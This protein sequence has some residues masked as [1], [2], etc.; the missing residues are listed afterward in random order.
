[1]AVANITAMNGKNS[2]IYISTTA[3]GQIY[4][5]NAWSI[6]LS[7]DNTEYAV[8]DDDWKSN[9]SGLMGYSLTIGAVSD[10]ATKLLYTAAVYDGLVVWAI[11]P[12]SNDATTYYS[13]S[14]VFGMGASGEMGSA[15]MRTATGV[16]SGTLSATGFS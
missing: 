13:G 7:H 10:Q 16:G 15:V 14:A 3:S 9:F 2:L 1:M 8:F 6:D 12:Q 4:G 11:Y 5:A